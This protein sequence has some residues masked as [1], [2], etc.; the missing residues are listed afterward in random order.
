[1][2]RALVT[3]ATSGIG[4][5]FTRQLAAR[6]D[7][8]VLVARDETRLQEVAADLR[9]RYA[10]GVEVLAADL[11]IR[12]DVDRVASRITA[13][14][15]PI[16]LV[17]NNAGFGMV[18][19]TL[20]PDLIEHDRAWAV[21]GEAV[22]VLSHAAGRTMRERGEGQI[23]NVASL[24]GWI[25]QGHYSALKSYVKVYTEGLA[26]ELR[27]TGVTA[28]AL[29]PGWVHTEFHERANINVRKLPPW[30]W[31]DAETCV[32]AA[33][34]DADAGRVISLPTWKW[35]V[36]GFGLQHLPRTAV[37]AISRRLSSIRRPES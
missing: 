23:I 9:S 12:S 30:V 35:K 37:R 25:T 19:P 21:M 31:V 20:G 2:K 28:T 3:G 11:S 27:G 16:T 29:C 33:L 1:M 10:V 5:A 36:A 14:D 4:A 7:D 22:V 15:Q 8:L 17:V 13:A 32:R 26:N 6:G 18:N 24:A 34:A